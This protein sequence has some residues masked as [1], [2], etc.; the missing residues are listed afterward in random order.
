MRGMCP[1]C[2]E[3]IRFLPNRDGDIAR[4]EH[5]GGKI[6]LRVLYCPNCRGPILL[7][8]SSH[9]TMPEDESVQLVYPANSPRPLQRNSV[10]EQIRKLYSE[11]RS[12]ELKSESAT[13]ALLRACLEMLLKDRGFD[14]KTLA[15]RI[16][17][18]RKDPRVHKNLGEKLDIVREVGN[19]GL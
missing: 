16:D 15:Q 19:F 9:I 18:A 6:S 2:G 11:A 8:V 12:V 4:A 17:V 1:G 13:A 14:G 7:I 3:M 10:P 5:G